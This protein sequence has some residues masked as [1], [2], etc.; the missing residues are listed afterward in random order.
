MATK[1]KPVEAGDACPQCGGTFVLDSSQNPDV[2]IDSVK[3]NAQ[4]DAAA[5]RYAEQ[6]R[7][8]AEQHGLIHVCSQCGYRSRFKPAASSGQEAAAPAAATAKGR[9]SA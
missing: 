9:A 5:A 2:R 7:E 1:S 8:K 3:R 6:T 4:N